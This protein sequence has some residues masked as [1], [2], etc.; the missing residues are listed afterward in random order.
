MEVCALNSSINHAV[1]L[2]FNHKF[3]MDE[4]NINNTGNNKSHNVH[5]WLTP[6]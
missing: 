6:C 2:D 4:F 1:G 3:N 5:E